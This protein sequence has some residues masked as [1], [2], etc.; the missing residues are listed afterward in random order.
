MAG[1]GPGTLRTHG[2]TLLSPLRLLGEAW[3]MRAGPCAKGR[4]DQPASSVRVRRKNKEDQCDSPR[5]RE[6]SQLTFVL[7]K[8]A[9]LGQRCHA[10]LHFG[11]VEAPSGPRTAG[12]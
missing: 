8:P 1:N 6:M 11:F 3:T 10:W 4:K 12:M 9:D 5:V 7:R 2:E